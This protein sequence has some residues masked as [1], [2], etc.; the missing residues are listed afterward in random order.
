VH[1]PRGACR[2]DSPWMGWVR[3]IVGPAFLVG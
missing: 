2:K 3:G 1:C